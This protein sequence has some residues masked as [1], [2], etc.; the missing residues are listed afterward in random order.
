M[1]RS[2]PGS[3][4]KAAAPR[5]KKKARPEVPEYH[6]TPSRKDD[7]GEIIWPAPKEQIEQA[8]S[9]ILECAGAGKR[10]LIVPDKDADGLSSGAILQR[11]L[12]LL[13]L[14]PELISVHLLRKGNNIHTE[15]E[16][17]AMADIDPEYIFI[18]DQGSRKAPPVIDKP[19]KALVI[20]HHFAEE[21]DFPEGS[22]H[23]TACNSPPVATSS[24]LTYHLCSA[25]HED[26]QQSCAW[27]CVLGTH[28]DLGTTL[29]WEPPFP[30]MRA[31]FKTY[32]KKAL[33]EAVSMINA[34]RRAATFDV[35][36]AW[37]ALAAANAPADL[38]NNEKLLAARAEVKAE[39]ERCTHAAP[40]F[41]ADGKIAVFRIRSAAQDTSQGL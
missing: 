20:D 6:L 23:V 21:D 37:A 40:K 16:R 3:G 27:L 35:P 1:K 41:S 25:V 18:L 9:F 31:T 22:K 36:V 30:D 32:T 12:I 4:S 15:S 19:H 17:Q 14:E 33:N 10:T 7:A 38:A 11:T 13:G 29:K 8:K 39:V 26:V 34:P 28:G 24:L 2:A 5:T